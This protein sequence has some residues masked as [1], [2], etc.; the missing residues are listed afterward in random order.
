M[1]RRW[2]RRLLAG[3]VLVA[4]PSCGGSSWPDLA[5][6]PA[7]DLASAEEG[8]REQL[9][10]KRRSLDDLLAAEATPVGREAAAETFGELGLLY[11]A[12]E[13]L[14]AAEVCLE[15]AARLQPDDYRWTY[16]QGY[17]L[18]VQG[19]LPEA[20]ERYRRAQSRAPDFL[21]LP[22]RLGRAHLDLGDG[23]EARRAF[24]R[25]L[26]LDPQAAA[27]HE[28]LGR[29]AAMEGDA[30]AAVAAFERALEL[31]PRASGVY[32]A[33]SQALREL[34]RSEAAD[35]ALARRGDV[36]TRIPDPLI[37]SLASVAESSQFYL[38]QGAEALDDQRFEDAVGAY[39]EAI[40]RDGGQLQAHRG[41]AVALDGLGDTVGAAQAL[42]EGL[43]RADS[44]TPAAEVGEATR[45]LGSLLVRLD[46][47]GEAIDLFR[48]SLGAAPDQP[49]VRLALANSLA[50]QQRW[51]EAR[52]EFDALI[53]AMPQASPVL[54]EK[55]GTV[56]LQLGERAEALEDFRQAAAADPRDPALRQRLMR[57]FEALGESRAASRERA[58]LQRLAGESDS[59]TLLAAAEAR[60]R[61]GDH[62]G[63]IV[64]YREV[65]EQD[66][67]ALPARL[68]LA[69]VLGHL[70]RYDEAAEEFARLLAA[71]PRSAAAHRGRVVSL[72]LGE[73]Y[74]ECR[75]ALQ[76]ALRSFP[77][78][79]AF[80]L[81]QVRLLASAPDVRVRDGALALEIARRLAEE[82]DSRQVRSVLALAHAEAGLFPRAVELER[83]LSSSGER[84]EAFEAGRAWISQGPD[85]LL[86]DLR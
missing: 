41:V 62:A 17:L 86:V 65:L 9:E 45:F 54:L 43:D 64:A 27:G 48:R 42:A 24:E 6:L 23:A 50:R 20:V 19:R 18:G 12:Y 37:N 82:D 2:C 49:A 33:L 78:D 46:R 57:A 55:R 67:S 44:A 16:L 11:V 58:A 34:G 75:V 31:E 40:A 51:Q 36:A 84:L 7:L 28:G 13:F 52:Q 60:V 83:G 5:P 81:T 63:A 15:N 72:L 53:A 4:L 30:A 38:M 56:L 32:Y 71:A 69:S 74:G 25:A 80:A 8:A 61:A 14:A 22:L 68:G 3:L 21:P 66:G 26:E 39:R 47:E 29:V 85:E 77:R 10:G 59:P 70:G 1:N 79:R 35:T 73:R 76:D